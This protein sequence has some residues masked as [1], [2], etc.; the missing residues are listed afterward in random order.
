LSLVCRLAGVL[1]VKEEERALA[2]AVRLAEESGGKPAR[3]THEQVA[4]LCRDPRLPPWLVLW[5]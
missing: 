4:Q 3:V 2:S 5:R 1:T